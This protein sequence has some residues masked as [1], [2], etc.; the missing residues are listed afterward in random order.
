MTSLSIGRAWD[1]TRA[2]LAER[3]QLLAAVALA[4]IT[5]PMTLVALIHPGGAAAGNDRSLGLV[6]LVAV[7]VALL[8]Q[9]AMALIA[10][11]GADSVGQAI[12]RAA[13]RL[14]RPIVA[15]LVVL[16]PVVLLFSIVLALVAGPALE[17]GLTDP[18]A[19]GPGAMIVLALF[20]V[21]LVVV[22][23]RLCLMFV[24]AV[25]E[26]HGVIALLRR[27]LALSQGHFARL[28]ALFA[29]LLLA[30]LVVSAA[31]GSVI[32]LAVSTLVGPAE[33][34]SVAAL[35]MALFGGLVQAG[36]STVYTVMLTR[37]YDQLA[38]RT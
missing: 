23:V 20:V 30:F 13:Q 22:T 2:V 11:P 21:A 31:I 35:I 9:M 16:M 6:T 34:W 18:A 1:E 25:R 32:G 14:W 36:Y 24:V 10:G 12:G 19:I 29:M 28:L 38:T 26:D 27:T 5:L 4:L 7:A 37:V 3:G 17:H 33:P 8:G 15:S